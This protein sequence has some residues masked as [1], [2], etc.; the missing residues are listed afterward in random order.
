MA[1]DTNK[2]YPTGYFAHNYPLVKFLLASF[3]AVLFTGLAICKGLT[4]FNENHWPLESSSKIS[5]DWKHYEWHGNIETF[6][7]P[8][9]GTQLFAYRA[10]TFVDLPLKS[11]MKVFRDTPNHINWTK[12]LIETEE[13]HKSAH[14]KDDHKRYIETEILRQRYKYPIPGI[15]DRE[16][17]M[18]KT[19]T[20]NEAED[21]SG[22]SSV[23]V[24]LI[25]VEDDEKY[26]VCHDCI[27]GHNLGST[28]T[29]TTL[30]G[31]GGTRIVADI[32]INPEMLSLS[33]FIIN[34]IQKKWH[35]VTMNRMIK[36]CNNNAG[37]S[38][39]V[40]MHNILQYIYPIKR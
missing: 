21:G 23:T 15:K 14:H 19:I 11:V 7:R 40:N 35:L 29:F 31:E 27:R 8:I 4:I 20:N 13:W 16:Y 36:I 28:W 32:A 38:E 12:G 37:R 39:E 34:N 3:L 18:H 9:A 5:D 24:E 26:S 25:S 17:L 33:P 10:A 30:K 6:R 2:K 22:R 1:T